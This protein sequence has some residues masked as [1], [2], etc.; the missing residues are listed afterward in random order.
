MVGSISAYTDRS[1]DFFKFSQSQGDDYATF[2]AEKE[3]VVVGCISCITSTV[4]IDGQIIKRL[5]MGDLKV[6]PEAG[7]MNL[8]KKLSSLPLK[9]ALDDKSYGLVDLDIIENNQRAL[10]LPSWIDR[11][12]C[13][14]KG[15]GIL[16]TYQ[17]MPFRNYPKTKGYSVRPARSEDVPA[18]AQILHETYKNYDCSPLFDE[19]ALEKEL[20]RTSS[21]NIESFRV[22]ER[23]GVVVACA[24][25]W[26]QSDIRKTV[27]TTY[28]LK[29]KITLS[30][31]S[32][33]KLFLAIPTLPNPGQALEYLYFRFP[34]CLPGEQEAIRA[35]LHAECNNLRFAKKYHFIWAGFHENDPLLDTIS[36]IWKIK[37]NIKTFHFDPRTEP[38][39]QTIKTNTNRLVYTDLALI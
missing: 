18:M 15:T 30:L 3:G 20:K 32:F 4:R 10:K 34:G 29:V 13:N 25:F 35:I 27:V 9:M 8:A 28:S 2:I 12:V 16:S 11:E 33:L 24:A 22:A 37:F 5:Y 21:F 38:K 17:L 6:A 31:L 19:G 36:N 39:N 14:L 23:N 26:D 7:R 1:P